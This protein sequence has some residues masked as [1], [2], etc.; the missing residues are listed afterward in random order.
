MAK[1]ERKDTLNVWIS[2]F[3]LFLQH[4]HSYYST[5]A[6]NSLTMAGQ[7]RCIIQMYVLIVHNDM[8]FR[9]LGWNLY[10]LQTQP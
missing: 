10:T 9:V 8:G 5:S 1:N 4:G 2:L 3:A 6:G 7:T